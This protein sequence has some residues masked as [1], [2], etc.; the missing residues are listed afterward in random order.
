[1]KRKIFNFF[2]LIY[3]KL[4]FNYKFKKKLKGI[5]YR[6][7]G[8]FFKNT[9]SYRVWN[10][11]NFKIDN[12]AKVLY[13]EKVSNTYVCK[14]NIA[15]QLHLFYT[16]LIDE[17]V[18]YLSN[19]PC[20]FDI[21][22]SIV[23]K[24]EKEKVY[25]I[26]IKTTNVR[27]VYVEVVKNRGRD[28]APLVSTFGNRILQYDFVCHI[29]SKKS[30]FTG[31]EQTEWRHYLLEG[32]LGDRNIINNHLYQ[33][34]KGDRIGLLYPETFYMMPYQG[35]TWLQN[36]YSRDELLE[37]IG[38]NVRTDEKYFDYPMGTMFW[39]KVEAIKQFFKAGIETDEFPK[40]NR[41]ND[42]TIAHAFERCLGLVNRYNGFNLLVFN[43]ESKTYLYS[44]NKNLNQYLI[45][46]YEG[47]E[48]EL[49]LYDIVSFDIFDTLV[50]RKIS[51]PRDILKLLEM[52]IDYVFKVKSNF[53]EI[54]LQA[55]SNFRNRN[56]DLD[57]DLRQIYNLIKPS[58]ILK[59]EMIEMAYNTEIE[60]EKQLLEPKTKVIEVLKN[61][62]HKYG[63]EVCL[64]SDMQLDLEQIKQILK[65]NHIN[66]DIK[67]YLSSDVNMR[68]DNGTMWKHYSEIMKD[69]KCIHIGDDEVSDMQI[70]G[71]YKISNY[72]IFGNETLFQLSNFGK[73]IGYVND[74]NACDS[75]ELGL[76]YNK[77]FS[78]P[79]AYN[80]SNFKVTIDDA[81]TLGYSVFGPVVLNYILWLMKEAKQLKAKTIL[82]FAREGYI[83]K[84]VYD[85]I[86]NIYQNDVAKSKYLYV[87]RRALSFATIFDDNDINEILD[88]YYEGKL[89]T[90]LYERF[91]IEY[92][93]TKNE[94]IKLP[95]NKNKVLK[96]I[97]KYK[98]DVFE[99]AAK[100]RKDYIEY[101]KNVV[102]D[103]EN[104]VVSDIGYSGT[105]QYYLSKITKTSFHGRYFA[106]NEKKTAEKIFENTM[107]G[108]Y[109]DNDNEQEL[110]MS[111]IH[112]YHL[113]LESILIAPD[114]QLLRIENNNPIFTEEN[115]L[116]NEN[117][118]KIHEGIIQ[119]S[120]DYAN[121]LGE[122][123]LEEIPQK[124]LAEKLIET[125]IQ[126]DI[127]SDD[128]AMDFVMDDKYCGSGLRNA[129]E[130]Y[131]R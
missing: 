45:K 130:Y 33:L 57:C 90:L 116:F 128:I 63:K 53:Y 83:L 61:T 10:A 107:Y 47:L 127:V 35:H 74:N 79:F 80:K 48:Q 13:D 68:K 88:M 18:K 32:L 123:L 92:E 60:M 105:I 24:D 40:E 23:D 8:F 97:D 44:G 129:I 5:F 121:I 77:M 110:S 115:T 25:N 6:F 99:R 39:A 52:K 91:G 76:I 15:V 67:I 102:L 104:I 101:F 11:Q 82:F 71:D 72:H 9:T 119:Y 64:I 85:S 50:S 16:D 29:H 22:V 21:L 37:R 75:V 2:K 27:N 62:I 46:S 41:Q 108:Y 111:S 3:K 113:L 131:K 12:N 78:D 112:K 26:L 56:I 109:I 28:V 86:A 42:G 51:E 58:N 114:G 118:V 17:F 117:I 54:R 43:N 38:V 19:M 4:P 65:N 36:K 30:L 106:T 70:P 59:K 49:K 66:E 95:D 14:K 7:F 126:E 120:K 122:V 84:K 96:I 20:E 94:D 89:N 124:I 93:D 100:E 69:K 73:C 55:E 125:I 34:E 31:S 1:M 81:R 87:S 98:K 103:S